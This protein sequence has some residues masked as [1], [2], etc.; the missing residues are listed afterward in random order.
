MTGEKPREIALELLLRR[1][2][3][4]AFIEALLEETFQTISMRPEDRR[5][6][7]ELTFG[8]VR[9]Q[10]TLD[11]LIDQKTGGKPQTPA[12]QILLRLALYQM[13]WLER[14]PSYAAVNESVEIAKARGFL[15]PAKFINAVLRGYGR[16][17]D[18]T[19]QRLQ[20][21]RRE[22][23]P[24][25]YSH[26]EWLYRNWT[27]RWGREEAVALME[28]NNSPPPVFARLNKLKGTREELLSKW[29]EEKV[30]HAEFACP[31]T[32]EQIVFQLMTPS[33]AGLPSF[34]E[35]WFYIQDP[36]TLLAVEELSPQ[37]GEEVL[38]LCSAP[39][40]KAAYIA[41]K[42]ENSGRIIAHDA[43]PERLRLVQA[44]AARLG[45]KNISYNLAPDA[46]FDRILID[47]PCSNTG[48]MRRRVD[49]R[50]RVKPEEIQR[51]AG[52]QQQLLRQAA[53]M[54]R[55]GGTLVYSTCSLEREENAAVVREFLDGHA[56]WRLEK[57]TELIPFKNGTDGA[58]VARLRLS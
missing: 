16:E 17:S 26:P 19:R 42:M 37:P 53:R 15:G 29:A 40:G 25:G 8:V 27:S 33:V 50:W 47:A 13:F 57:E 44:N 56:N 48:V 20:D 21:L 11:Y 28:W 36:S 10:S 24:V 54:L 12:V 46:I 32:K 23:P 7:Q 38:D 18:A 14:V 51:L 22:N 52:V 43:D 45:I 31:W 35:G 39:G 2:K 4:G 30:E 3:S 55:N 49:L 34:Q 6:L 58:Y 41:A 9:W 5:F 1:Q